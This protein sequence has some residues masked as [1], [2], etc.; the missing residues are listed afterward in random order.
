MK[1]R[2]LQF[3]EGVFAGLG[4]G[5]ERCEGQGF[6]WTSR[7]FIREERG[8]I[9]SHV[10]LLEY[11]VLVEGVRCRAAALHAVATRESHRG[12]GLA[13]SLIE[14]AIEWARGRYDFLVLYTKIPAFYEPFSFA[15]VEECRFRLECAREKGRQALEPLEAAEVRR[16]FCEREMLSG[17]VWVE[18]RGEIA[19]LNALFEGFPH[20]WSFHYAPAID[21]ILS[22]VVK[23]KTVHLFDVIARKIPTLEMILDHLPCEIDE[24]YFYF[25][26]E[27]LT[28]EALPQPYSHYG[29]L[30]MVRGVW[31]EVKPFMVPPLS[32][33]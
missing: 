10:G 16:L 25:S 6:F 27:R 32:R 14:E 11:P 31:P 21:A 9:V 19:P 26:P 2:V 23:E 7:P 22:F 29:D 33:C 30:L 20:F 24:I 3:L 8:E 1:K 12:Q 13:S 5:V 28:D 4:S 17:Q 15:R 18:D